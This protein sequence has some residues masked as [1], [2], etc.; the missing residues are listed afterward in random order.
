MS[1]QETDGVVSALAEFGG[2]L[3]AGGDFTKAG[4][5]R[6]NH[7]ASWD[8][9]EWDSLCSRMNGPVYAVAEFNGNLVVGRGSL[10]TSHTGCENP[11][12]VWL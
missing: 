12:V 6:A 7:V 4:C 1:P 8:G 2:E 10:G 11:L 3:T 5:A 9:S